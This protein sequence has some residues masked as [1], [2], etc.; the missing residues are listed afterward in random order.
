MFINVT[1]KCISSTFVN[2][3]I[4]K[5]IKIILIEY[6]GRHKIFY[7]YICKNIARVGNKAV[8]SNRNYEVNNQ[9]LNILT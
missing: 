9:I 4:L 6:W 1:M 7:A 2:K 5:Y 3:N 8:V